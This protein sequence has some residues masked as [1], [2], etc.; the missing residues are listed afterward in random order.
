MATSTLSVQITVAWWLP[1]YVRTLA[2]VCLTMGT[3]PDP[4]K[5]ARV[6]MRAVRF[7]LVPR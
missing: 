2:L 1:L 5:V 3:Q 6:A 7:R 4:M